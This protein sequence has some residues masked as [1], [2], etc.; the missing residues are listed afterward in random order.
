MCFLLGLQVLVTNWNLRR[1][2]GGKFRRQKPI[3]M[4]VCMC[5]RICVK[6]KEGKREEREIDFINN[7]FP[8]P[9]HLGAHK[10]DGQYR[11]V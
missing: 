10:N 9:N 1:R 3:S 8:P 2:E 4:Y 5:I 7:L 6:Q 11:E